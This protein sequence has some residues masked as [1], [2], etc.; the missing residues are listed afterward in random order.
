MGV[1]ARAGAIL[2]EAYGGRIAAYYPNFSDSPLARVHYIVGVRTGHRLAP[3]MAQLEARITEAAR[4]W[5]DRFEASI[6]AVTPPGA[7]A[8]RLGAAR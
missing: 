8:A 3:D 1:R 5:G 2:A 6:R 4:T 7:I